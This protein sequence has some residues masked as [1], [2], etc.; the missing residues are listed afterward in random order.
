MVHRSIDKTGRTVK[1]RGR[2]IALIFAFFVVVL[3]AGAVLARPYLR[4]RWYD[5]R[6]AERRAE[7]PEAVGYQKVEQRTT[8]T[9]SAGV[10]ATPVV[11]TTSPPKPAVIVAT[12]NLKIPFVSQAPHRNWNMPYQEA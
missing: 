10:P 7:L 5:R 11:V 3:G 1:R 9:S 2:R 6:D 12:V 8:T 4:E